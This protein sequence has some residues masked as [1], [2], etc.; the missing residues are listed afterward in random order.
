MFI[1][2][3]IMLREGFEAALIIGILAG[4]LVQ[5][6]RSNALPSLWVGVVAALIG[7][8]V[9]GLAIHFTGAELPQNKQEI[10]EG[11][12]G[13]L[14]VFMLLSMV[15]WMRRAGRTIKKELQA[16]ADSSM[17]SYVTGWNF[18]LMFVA[19]LVT[20]R[21]GVESVIFLIA[22]IEQSTGLGVPVGAALGLLSAT[23]LG[24]AVFRGGMKIDM[25][26]F[27]RWTGTFV[28]LVAG[29]LIAGSVNH[30]HEGG[31]WNYL[32]GTAFNLS[33]IL[34]SDGLAGTLLG[35]LFGYRDAPSV[36]EVVAYLAFTIPALVLFLMPHGPSTRPAPQQKPLV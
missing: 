3:L 27:F 25:R 10:F 16:K 23:F 7:S 31:I 13:I 34:P 30:F 12:V 33:D 19:F 18:S 32:Q 5:T 35:G 11:C 4:Y 6:G 14:A 15:F 20:G 22:V 21:E 24:W 17:Q 1:S 9:L 28:I 29:G 8:L 2:F 36:G 26:R